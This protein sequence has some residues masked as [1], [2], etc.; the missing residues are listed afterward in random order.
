MVMDDGPNVVNVPDV[1]AMP[2]LQRPPR[3][4]SVVHLTGHRVSTTSKHPVTMHGLIPTS[5]KLVGHGR[6]PGAG[7]PLNEV[8]T[9]THVAAR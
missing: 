5:S 2:L 4:C 1:V 3:V 9:N 6:L 8:V 7:H